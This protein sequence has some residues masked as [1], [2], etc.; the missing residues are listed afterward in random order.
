MLKVFIYWSW[1]NFTMFMLWKRLNI[2]SPKFISNTVFPL[3]SAAAPIIWNFFF[4]FFVFFHKVYVIF[5]MLYPSI[6]LVTWTKFCNF[7]PDSFSLHL[8]G[9]EFNWKPTKSS[10][11]K[12]SPKNISQLS[13]QNIV[14][15]CR[16]SFS[17]N[18]WY[19]IRLNLP[20]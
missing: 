4:D 11:K 17:N 3:F 2:P 1:E 14:I 7:L 20:N 6:K 16:F 12:K 15:F 19:Y 18:V 13:S 5:L 10:C 8:W 9:P